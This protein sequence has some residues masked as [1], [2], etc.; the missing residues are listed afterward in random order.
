VSIAKIVADK[1]I[2]ALK[3]SDGVTWKRPWVG[4]TGTPLNASTNRPYRGVN[5]FT[6]GWSASTPYWATYNQWKSLG[7]QVQKGSKA[8]YIIAPRIGKDA[9]TGEDKIFGWG[10]FPVFNLT[11][12]DGWTP[13]DVTQ[14]EDAVIDPF[15][16]IDNLI[17][18]HGVDLRHSIEARAYY[19][20]TDDYIHM[21]NR[22]TFRA[23]HEQTAQQSYYS[24]LAHEMIHWTGHSSRI[25]RLASTRETKDY[26]FEELIA[27]L[28]QSILCQEVGLRDNVD[29]NEIA[30][31][32]SWI[33]NL[34]NDPSYIVK[35][36]SQAEKAVQHLIA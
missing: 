29:S 26:A 23:V 12:V 8:E 36:A 35:A 11:Q 14:D 19:S 28:G 18:K 17:I 3:S 32:K 4:M 34:S 33:A 5:R 13:D 16:A 6:L 20:P 10:A 21:P 24:T 30:Y 27:E 25:D 2:A 22:E 7:A 15:D 1:V 31:I 9:K